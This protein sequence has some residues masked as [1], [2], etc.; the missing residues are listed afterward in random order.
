MSLYTKS[1]SV[2]RTRLH[3]TDSL[4]GGQNLQRWCDNSLSAIYNR[5][6]PELKKMPHLRLS[7]SRGAG[8]RDGPM[9]PSVKSWDLAS[10]TRWLKSPANFRGKSEISGG[11]A[12]TS[13]IGMD[14]PMGRWVVCPHP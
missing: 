4:H 6:K 3:C 2:T 11:K 1:V 13:L 14:G 5:Q 10:D 9:G 7:E 8:R 12:I